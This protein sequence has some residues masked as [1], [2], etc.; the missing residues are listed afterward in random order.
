MSMTVFWLIAFVIFAV[1]EG[2]TVGLVSIWFAIGALGGM[3]AAAFGAGLWIQI[4]VF[5]AV[6]A[7]SLLLF[8][9][10]SKKMFQNKVSPTNADRV[11]GESAVVTETV[12]NSQARGQ[13]RVDGQ[14]WSARSAHD[15]VI[16]A[17]TA[18]RVLRIEGVKV[19]VET[20]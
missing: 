11:L 17:G 13:V 3:A 5:L 20:L 8:K 7:L 19:I 1:C 16:P 2:L 14:I 4:G 15:L 9:P 18:V 10:I 12:D 6:S